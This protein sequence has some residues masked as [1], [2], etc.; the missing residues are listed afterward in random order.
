MKF[1]FEMVE[2]EVPEWLFCGCIQEAT[3]PR[4]RIRLEKKKPQP[5]G[6]SRLCMGRM[7]LRGKKKEPITF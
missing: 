4:G 2:F 3:G 6:H 7:G 5:L 1:G